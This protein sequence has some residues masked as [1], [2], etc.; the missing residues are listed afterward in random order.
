MKTSGPWINETMA[1]SRI[2]A[3][4]FSTQHQHLLLILTDHDHHAGQR[5]RTPAVIIPAMESAF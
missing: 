5:V 2:P 3:L 1:R 4:A